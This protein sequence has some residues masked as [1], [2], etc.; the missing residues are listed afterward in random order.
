MH[1]I[2]KANTENA[3]NWRI[4]INVIVPLFLSKGVS[5]DCENNKDFL[6]YVRNIFNRYLNRDWG[7]LG[8]EDWELNDLAVDNRDD[9]ILA[10]YKDPNSNFEDIYIIT[11]SDFSAT[12]ILFTDEY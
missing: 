8:D 5:Y 11:E 10:R 7:D 4:N 12:T 2:T 6:L 3:K 1:T 9:R